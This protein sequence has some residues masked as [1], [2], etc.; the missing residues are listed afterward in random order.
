MW[1]KSKYCEGTISQKL[2]QGDYAIEGYE[3]LMAIERKGAV[4]EW[5]NNLGVHWDRF[6]RELERSRHIKNFWIILEFNMTDVM[7]FPVGSGIPK[8]QWSYLKF[9]GP[10]LLKRMLEIEQTYPNVH[11][12]LA[13]GSGKEVASSIFKRTTEQIDAAVKQRKASQ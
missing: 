9:K 13:G 8:R 11:I 3:D 5:A 1:N 7:N 6:E 2:D 4:S 10:F 12:V